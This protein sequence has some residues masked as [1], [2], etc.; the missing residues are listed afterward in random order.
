MTPNEPRMTPA[1]EQSIDEVVRR[2]L[3]ARLHDVFEQAAE[4]IY[5]RIQR[6]SGDSYPTQTRAQADEVREPVASYDLGLDLSHA[7]IRV[8]ERASR[9]TDSAAQNRGVLAAE[10]VETAPDL[11]GT[12][13]ELQEQSL[14]TAEAAARLGV[15]SSRIR[16]RLLARTLYGFKDHSSWRIPEFQFEGDH[17]VPGVESVFPEIRLSASPV[18]VARWFVLPW[19]DLVVDEERE[20]V[21]SPKTWLLQGRDPAP[22]IAQAHVI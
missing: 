5:A 13:M 10:T 6:I 19:E 8:F 1:L 14:S 2:K 18:T 9:I 15:N 11:P 12:L 7:L 16:Q 20:T 21:V 3:E 4:E 22:V 17:L